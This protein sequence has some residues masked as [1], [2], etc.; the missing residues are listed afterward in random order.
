MTLVTPIP[1]TS[2]IFSLS[3][4]KKAHELTTEKRK[5]DKLLLQ[6]LPPTV[7]RR[8]WITQLVKKEFSLFFIFLFY[9]LFTLECY[10]GYPA[11]GCLHQNFCLCKQ[12]LRCSKAC[13]CSYFCILTLKAPNVPK[14]PYEAFIFLNNW[15]QLSFRNFSN[16]NLWF[17]F[18][19]ACSSIALILTIF[20]LHVF[21]LMIFFMQHECLEMVAKAYY[22]C[23]QTVAV[24]KIRGV[25]MFMIEGANFY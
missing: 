1:A 11:L 24:H 22:L 20:V 4:A 5:A 8:V 7:A 9:G 12:A 2:Q 10:P 18:C 25:A 3:L 6:M 13:H 16:V 21:Y 17:R 14:R 15:Y 19:K 23:Y